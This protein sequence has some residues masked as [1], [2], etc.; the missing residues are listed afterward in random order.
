MIEQKAQRL[1]AA[2]AE[3]NLDL[4]NRIASK[5]ETP[6]E[7]CETDPASGYSPLMMAARHGHVEIAE[8]LIRLGHDRAEISRVSSSNERRLPFADVTPLV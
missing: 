6:E 4:V 7:L 2:C 8:L 5:F 1:L 3:G